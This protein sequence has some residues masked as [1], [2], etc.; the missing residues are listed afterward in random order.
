MIWL[1]NTFIS[2][3]KETV[4]D[5]FIP[6]DSYICS[7]YRFLVYIHICLWCVVVP[8]YPL[9]SSI[10]R[11]TQSEWAFSHR[12]RAYIVYDLS[13][14]RMDVLNPNSQGSITFNL[15]VSLSLST[16][17]ESIVFHLLLLWS[18]FHSIYPLLH[19]F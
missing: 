9:E 1:R 7:I 12:T 18:C 15:T 17:N 14:S 8:N 16:E 13:Y 6:I 4:Y 11:I 5:S 10:E 3:A 19:S 2:I